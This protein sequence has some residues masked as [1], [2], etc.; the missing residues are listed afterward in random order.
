[1]K[2]MAE[3]FYNLSLN[4]KII[5]LVIVVGFLPLGIIFFVSFSEINSRSQERQS[6]AINQG[7]S[8]VRQ[9]VED[10]LS[11]VQNISTLLAVN[12]MVNLTL[13]LTG[14]EENIAEQL[15]YF[16]NIS[17]Y[18]YGMEMTFESNNILFYIEDSYPVVNSFSSRYR[19]L[20]D[21]MET[22]WYQELEANNGRPT[23]V[24]YT[25]DVYDSSKS[26]V[27]VTRKLW[28]QDNYNYAIGVLAVIFERQYLEDMLIDSTRKQMM[29]LESAEGNLL[30]G[31]TG[32]DELVRLPLGERGID[33]KEFGSMNID[34]TQYLVRGSLIEKANVYLISVIPQVS[35][36]QETIAVNMRMW[37]IYLT[38][39]A[40][41]I[42]AFIPLTRI[43]TGQIKLLKK[44]M[45]QI[46]KG[47]IQKVEVEHEYHDEIGQLITHYNDMVEKV[48]ELMREQYA[49]GQE[50]TG[51]ELKALQSQIN[52]HFLYNTLDMISW[53]AQKNEIDN[54]RNVVQAMSRFYRLTLSKGMDIVTIGDEIRMCAA[55]M[56]IQK[57]RYK[58][59]INYEEEVD[60]EILEYLIPKITLQPFLENA[61]IH[62]INEKE[63]TRGHVIL[64]GWMEDERIIL[65]VTDDGN[66]MR[67]EDKKNS[68]E[69]SH[70]GMENIAKR[71][72]LYYGEEIPIQVESSMGIGTCIIINIPVR[73][74]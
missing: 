48:E 71:L 60:E 65:S 51:A 72:S 30:A 10:K 47:I 59:R 67:P 56:E 45:L 50:K 20:S 40:F 68:P 62:G 55:Y 7:Y 74:E 36:E 63:D 18:A 3:W 61:I 43:I 33:D 23:W 32:E 73:K 12:D 69:G 38:V 4:R 15:A 25:E 31:N 1:M 11:R 37:I 13:R 52:P 34:G 41:V 29:Y 14:E 21:A 8:Q 54:I 26:Y 17:S 66:G 5:L 44:Q 28:N 57:R 70:Y 49:L 35:M 2:R 46:Q 27:A 22:D 19:S 16:E 9:A 6:Y 53:M 64:N 39:C 24:S 42:L 58:G